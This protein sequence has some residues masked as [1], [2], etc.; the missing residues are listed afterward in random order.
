MAKEKGEVPHPESDDRVVYIFAYLLTWISGI[1]VYI[2]L[3]Q[4]N[5]RMK[6]HA[7]QAI[8]LGIAAFIIAWI[9]IPFFFLIG[10]LLWLYGMYVG[11]V[12]YNGRDI[13]MPI[14]GEYA[15]KYS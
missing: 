12:A 4:K 9:P 5:K 1:L 15:E 6:F 13:S 3:G 14:I 11:V 10:F 7:L 8:M 2:T